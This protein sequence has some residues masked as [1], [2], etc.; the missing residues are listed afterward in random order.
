MMAGKTDIWVYAD[1]KSMISPK[2]IGILSAQQA[3]GRKAFSFSYDADWINS[4][5]Q[6]LL[7]PDIAWYSGQQY[8]NGKENFGVFLD[9]MPDTW[10]RTLMKRRAALNAKEQG[11]PTPVLYDIDFL[12]G[13]HDLSRMGALRFKREPDGD[14]LDN[15]PVSPTPPWAS[16]RELQHAAKLIESNEDT[17]EVRKWLAML[18]APGSSLGGTRPKANILDEHGHPWIAK[19]PSRND[20]IDKGAW[21]YLAYR[22]AVGAGIDM[23]ES[24]I[25]HIAGP[26]HTFFTKRFDR[27]KQDRIHFASAMTMT[28]KNEE[29]IRDMTPSYLDIVEFIQFSGTKIEADLHQLWR[30]MVFNIL[31]SNT[32][33]H[34]RNH[35]F[36]LTSEGWR[37]SPAFDIN[38]SIDK[39][40]LELNIDMDSN[41]PDIDLAKSVGVYFRLG[42]K[43][44]DHI[45]AEIQS[46]VMGWQKIATEIGISRNEQTLMATAFRV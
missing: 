6:L 20:T 21:E 38:P 16:I 17:V 2:C 27:E 4:Q 40:G 14:F 33:D 42:K 35:G 45:L 18:M 30:R 36:V 8:P 3:K 28:G 7:D 43:E 24:R 10:G 41:S 22:L 9:S 26:Y 37:L 29:L 34:L 15:D 23:A 46:V 44:M 32:D 39:V 12:L 5:E 25:E 13:V 11:K 1:W 19:F 31:I